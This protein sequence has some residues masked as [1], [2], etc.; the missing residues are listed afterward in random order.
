M[1]AASG[2]GRQLNAARVQLCEVDDER[3]TFTVRG[4]WL[5]EGVAP[6]GG[7]IRRLDD[8]GPAV[9]DLL[10]AGQ[11]MVVDDVLRD[12]RT[13][14]FGAAYGAMG[15]RANLAVSLLKAGRMV[16]I[17]SVQDAVPRRAGARPTCRPRPTGHGA[18]MDERERERERESERERERE[19]E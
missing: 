6:L 18:A 11:A 15:V 8:F 3:G 2:L 9:V 13:A 7:E 12:P 14:G 4:G 1:D 17:L 10:R 16:A 5:R 19:R